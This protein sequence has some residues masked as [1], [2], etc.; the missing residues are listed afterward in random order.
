MERYG[1]NK[2]WLPGLMV[3]VLLLSR[4]FVMVATASPQDGGHPATTSACDEPTLDSPGPNIGPGVVDVNLGGTNEQTVVVNPLDATNIAVASLFALRVST[5]NGATF[6]APTA[7][8]F[9]A[10]HVRCGD[11]SLAFDSQGRL[12]W[13][14][15]GC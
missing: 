14:Y 11:P 1:W 13:I 8:V 3:L 9:P 5:N 7:A 6:S 12:F 15:L 10:T 2:H 4:V